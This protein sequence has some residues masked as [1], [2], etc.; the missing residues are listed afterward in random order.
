MS[1]TLYFKKLV[2]MLFEPTAFF[3]HIKEEKSYAP[4][5]IFLFISLFISLIVTFILD[6]IKYRMVLPSLYSAG[7]VVV[8]LFISVN[9]TALVGHLFVYICGG[10]KGLMRTYQSVLYG[11]APSIIFVAVPGLSYIAGLYGWILQFTGL[12]R[13]H[14]L[15]FWRVLLAWLVLPLILG[16]LLGIIGAF[17]IASMFAPI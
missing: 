5:F 17:Y 15:S 13:L 10:R 6:F 8:V 7:I 14:E 12:E 4:A 16:A 9:V 3:T 1:V 2:K 11:S